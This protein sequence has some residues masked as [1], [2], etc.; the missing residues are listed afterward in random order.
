MARA[1]IGGSDLFGAADDLHRSG[2]LSAGLCEEEGPWTHDARLQRHDRPRF[3]IRNPTS[4]S[5]SFAWRWRCHRRHQHRR[6]CR[7]ICFRPSTCRKW[8]WRRSTPACRRR[9]SKPTSPIR[10]S[11]SSPR[12]AASDHMESR[13]LLG[14]SIIK[15]YFQPGTNAD[16][17]VTQLSNLALADLKRLPPGTLPPVV[18]KFDASSLPVCSGDGEGRRPERNPA[19]RSGAVPDPQSDRGGQRRGNSR[20]V[21]RQVPAGDD[22]RRSVQAAVAAVERRWTWWTP[23]TTAT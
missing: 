20:R 2:R 16:A 11:A 13:S 6:A 18:L 9:I 21:R 22:L 3:S 15:V 19:S 8:W 10:W 17:D 7:W 14:V 1:I 12:P 23:S 5:S 4:S